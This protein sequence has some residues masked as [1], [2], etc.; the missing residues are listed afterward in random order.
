MGS[1]GV[2][3]VSAG[4]GERVGGM[5][6]GTSLLQGWETVVV[7]EIHVNNESVVHQSLLL[8]C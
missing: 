4:I 7:A 2:S 5:V 3:E 8:Y 1:D 6:N